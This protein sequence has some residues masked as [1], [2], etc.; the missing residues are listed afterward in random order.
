MVEV[1]EVNGVAWD[2]IDEI[3]DVPAPAGGAEELGKVIK[4]EVISVLETEFAGPG[5]YELGEVSGDLQTVDTV[6]SGE[7]FE[8]TISGGPYDVV[9]DESAIAHTIVSEYAVSGV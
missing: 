8:Y 9:V 2:P 3:N 4:Y 7:Q 1:N 6:G 5:D